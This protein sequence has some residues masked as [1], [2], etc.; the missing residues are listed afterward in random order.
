MY[1]SL[2]S[3]H[4]K[5]VQVRLDHMQSLLLC[6]NAIGLFSHLCL[7]SPSNF[8]P[9]QC[10]IIH[11]TLIPSPNLHSQHTN[12]NNTQLYNHTSSP[13]TKSLLFQA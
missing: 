12:T 13:C 1:H 7:D 5:A 11:S 9:R 4:C 6:Y 10:S 2:K 8:T 3:R